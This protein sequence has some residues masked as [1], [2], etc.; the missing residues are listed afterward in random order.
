MKFPTSGSIKEICGNQKKARMCYQTSFP[1]FGKEP[2][3][4]RKCNR[5]NHPEMMSTNGEARQENDNSPKER[6]NLKGPIPHEEIVKVPLAE[7]EPEKMFR[8][9]TMLEENHKE[10]M[11]CLIR[12]YKDIFAWGPKNMSGINI[13]DAP[14]VAYGVYVCSQKTK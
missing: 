11:I 6:E 10:D 13:S 9:G 4:S 12:K 8:I 7:K 2:E 5:E 3:K 1:P 14:Q